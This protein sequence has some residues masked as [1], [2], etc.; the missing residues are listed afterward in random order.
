MAEDNKQGGTPEDPLNL[1][2]KREEFLDSF[3]KRGAHFTMELLGEIDSLRKKVS[4]LSEENANL[5]THL[6]SDDA[7]RDLLTKIQKLEEDKH[8]LRTRAKDADDENR[9]YIDR[10]AVV[11]AELDAMANLY[12]ASFQ[13]HGTLAPKGVLSVLEQML[14]QFVGAASFAIFLRQPVD[15]EDLLI[16]AHAFHCDDVKGTTVPWNEGLIGESAATQINYVGDPSLRREGGEPL[17]CIPMVLGNET[18]GVIVIYRLLEQKEK[19][20]EI[21]YELFKLLALHSASAI[22]GAGLF[23]QTGG[24]AA[25]L[26]EYKRL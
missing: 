16:P 11:E 17:A 21:D 9:N 2:A 5:Q 18:V 1:T 10:Y 14:M 24:I 12:V 20:V 13:L 8:K 4:N 3:F 23:S 26:R 19:F 25:S 15:G 6:A 22:I 7:I